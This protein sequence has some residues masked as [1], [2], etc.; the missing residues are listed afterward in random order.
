MN[1]LISLK[2]ILT[3]NLDVALTIPKAHLRGVQMFK[4]PYKQGVNLA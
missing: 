4:L 1:N 2:S 3:N